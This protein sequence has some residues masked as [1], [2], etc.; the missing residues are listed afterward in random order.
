MSGTPGYAEVQYSSHGW[1]LETRSEVVEVVVVLIAC[2]PVTPLPP[3]TRSPTSSTRCATGHTL[4]TRATSAT[5]TPSSPASSRREPTSSRLLLPH[6]PPRPP[7]HL[8]TGPHPSSRQRARASA[9]TSSR[10]APSSRPQTPR[11]LSSTRTGLPQSRASPNPQ[12]RCAPAPSS[13]YTDTADPPLTRSQR[14]GPPPP[15]L[16]PPPPRPPPPASLHPQLAALAPDPAAAAAASSS[17]ALDLDDPTP[18]STPD[19]AVAL[20]QTIATHLARL[21]AFDALSTF[22]TES[23][24]P[25][26]PELTDDLLAQLRELHAILAELRDGTCT[27]A[28]EWVEHQGDDADP[29]RELEYALRREEFVNI[30]LAGASSDEAAAAAAM[31]AARAGRRGAADAMDTDAAPAPTSGPSEPLLGSLARRKSSLASLP[32]G[33]GA[34]DASTAQHPPPPPHVR[35]ALEYGGTHFRRLMTPARAHDI[36]ALLTCPLY[37]PLARLVASPYGALFL[38]EARARS[39]SALAAAFATAFLKACGLPSESPLTVVTDVG[40]GGALAKIMKVRAV[41]KEKRTEWSAVGELPVRRRLSP[42]CSLS[43]SGRARARLLGS[44]RTTPSAD[45]P[46]AHPPPSSSSSGRDPAPAPLPFP[47]DLCV[48]GLEGAEH[49][50]EPAHA[51]AVRPRHRAREPAAAREGDTVRRSRPLFPSRLRL[52]PKRFERGA[53]CR[54]GSRETRADLASSSSPARSTLKCPY[55][56]VVSHMSACVRVHF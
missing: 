20:N 28:L 16:F 49:G 31:A 43:L 4:P 37:L 18:F 42:S 54:G 9:T 12:T 27:R 8:Q 30:I 33:S 51:L 26:P 39:T 1:Q 11:A 21:G 5:S 24:T 52:C 15:P 35:A 19:V 13:S 22:L 38:P 45:D 10:S 23:G 41:M 6:H 55:C 36:C 56:P 25:T 7:A 32:G 14:F 3:W 48:P 2:W 34:G 40:G 50:A 29:G 46:L 53:V 47:L 44:S 17:A